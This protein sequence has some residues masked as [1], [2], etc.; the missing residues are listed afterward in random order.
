MKNLMIIATVI[1]SALIA[2]ADDEAQNENLQATPPM[3]I[4]YFNSSD[5]AIWMTV[6]N[7]I[8]IIGDRGCLQPGDFK[9]F[10]GYVPGFHY[11]V[12]VEVK[13]NRD[14][15]GHTLADMSELRKMNSWYGIEVY[16]FKRKDGRYDM[17]IINGDPYSPQDEEVQA[18]VQEQK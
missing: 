14:C 5:R 18:Q 12:R 4:R 2:K 11:Q 16:A 6:Y 15:G 1:L 13:E 7:A 10:I 3:V 9:S 17:T 8:G